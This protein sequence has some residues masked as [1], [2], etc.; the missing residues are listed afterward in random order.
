MKAVQGPQGCSCAVGF[1]IWDLHSHPEGRPWLTQHPC[2]PQD[3]L[4]ALLLPWGQ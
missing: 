4:L 1:Y 3:E 2:P